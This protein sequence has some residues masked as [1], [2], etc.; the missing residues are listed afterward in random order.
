MRIATFNLCLL[1]E[2]PCRGNASSRVRAFLES[3]C[4]GSGFWGSEDMTPPDVL[5]LQEVWD[6][7]LKCW[8]SVLEHELRK[9]GYS[10]FVKDRRRL[11]NPV[12]SGLMIASRFPIYFSEMSRF[13]ESS[14]I[15]QL[16]P[17]GFMSAAISLPCGKSLLVV[18]THMHAPTED[19]PWFNSPQTCERVIGSQIMELTRGVANQAEYFSKGSQGYTI[20]GGDFNIDARIGSATMQ[21]LKN[22]MKNEANLV[23]CVPRCPTYPYP[24]DGSSPLVNPKFVNQEC[25]VDYFLI[26][27]LGDFRNSVRLPAFGSPELWISDHAP[28]VLEFGLLD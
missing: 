4:L 18:N 7:W 13:R 6:T 2:F 16:V 12:N 14:G 28:V 5:L 11:F 9:K 21:L 19:T 17:R 26:S 8:S 25:C 20:V 22:T 10:Y 24:R 1:P 3:S 23:L 27:E 15:Q